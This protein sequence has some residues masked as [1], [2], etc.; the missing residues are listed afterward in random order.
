MNWTRQR[1]KLLNLCRL[2]HYNHLYKFLIRYGDIP[3]TNLVRID[4]VEHKK[5]ATEL[6][7]I[8]DNFLSKYYLIIIDEYEL[9][10]E[11]LF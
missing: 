9:V 1:F 11:L 10:I 2:K 4:G 3:L 8:V 5:M 7:A 6:S